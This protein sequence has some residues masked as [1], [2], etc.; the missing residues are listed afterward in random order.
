MVHKLKLD[1]EYENEGRKI[2]FKT[3]ENNIREN[4][5]NSIAAELEKN[6]KVLL[7]NPSL[8]DMARTREMVETL[9]QLDKLSVFKFIPSVSRGLHEWDIK[10]RLYGL[11]IIEKDMNENYT[12]QRAIAATFPSIIRRWPDTA[13]RIMDNY[14]RYTGETLN[15]SVFF[16][17]PHF[18]NETPV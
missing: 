15:L 11:D 3:I 12:I 14:I 1:I 2:D 7:Q 18:I 13:L 6:S 9:L 4:D 10:S 17:S 16:C 8:I 5:I